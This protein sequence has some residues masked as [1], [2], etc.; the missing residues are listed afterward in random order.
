NE[1]ELIL[2]DMDAEIKSM[3]EEIRCTRHY[4]QQERTQ[5]RHFEIPTNQGRWYDFL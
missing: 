1:K 4:L 2:S 5:S 3:G